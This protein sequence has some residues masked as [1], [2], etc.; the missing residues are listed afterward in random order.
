M[1]KI[2]FLISLFF[3]SSIGVS[4]DVHELNPKYQNGENIWGSA[5]CNGSLYLG[6]SPNGRIYRV[7]PP[8]VDTPMIKQIY[9]PD[10]KIEGPKFIHTLISSGNK[11]YGAVSNT[12]YLFSIN[13]INNTLQIVT[14]SNSALTSNG[15]TALFDAT[16]YKDSLQNKYIFF[17]SI[18]NDMLSF[19]KWKVSDNSD[20]IYV[21]KID[22][23]NPQ[24]QQMCQSYDIEIGKYAEF[25][26]E[27]KD[28]L[29]IGAYDDL[30]NYLV[31]WDIK[32]NRMIKSV[33]LPN[34]YII[35]NFKAD[36][37]RPNQIFV[38]NKKISRFD[39]TNPN[40]PPQTIIESIN[41]NGGS[42]NT[43]DDRFVYNYIDNDLYTNRGVLHTY[44]DP[45]KDYM[46]YYSDWKNLYS[47]NI[48]PVVD[49][50]GSKKI[51]G[52]DGGGLD[53]IFL[54]YVNQANHLYY[55][56][57]LHPLLTF[58]IGPITGLAA[59]NNIVYASQFCNR[60][61]MILKPEHNW[62]NSEIND[63][64]PNLNAVQSDK[65]VVW[66]SPSGHH[67]MI[68]G[69]YSGTGPFIKIKDINTGEK[70]G[71]TLS[72][73]IS[74]MQDRINEMTISQNNMLYM[75]TGT[76]NSTP[77]SPFILR[78]D[79]NAWEINK[80]IVGNTIPVCQMPSGRGMQFITSITC[81]SNGSND[82]IYSTIDH[83]SF[84]IIK[85]DSFG[86]CVDSSCY[87]SNS[88]KYFSSVLY[89]DSLNCIIVTECDRLY[90]IP[91]HLLQTASD[92][93]T[94]TATPYGPYWDFFHPESNDPTHHDFTVNLIKAGNGKFYCYNSPLT[95]SLFE[96]EITFNN[97]LP[98]PVH[99][100][101]IPVPDFIS[102]ISK[103]YAPALDSL[104]NVS[105]TANIYIGTCEGKIFIY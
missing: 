84:S 50:N 16:F 68:Y 100:H 13:S 5:Y 55:K 9:Q 105:S 90:I 8:D 76:S 99:T 22:L 33:H 64:I 10:Y 20:S 95:H 1:K 75:G 80:D 74:G 42:K 6:T 102:V 25:G 61:E 15:I 77:S 81:R 7:T 18:S 78:L 63:D 23:P 104:G 43:W 85:T 3:L 87:S 66:N 28:V 91:D 67:Y 62:I 94:Y 11:I 49:A 79:L 86:K 92:I 46:D 54:Y 101:R 58:P 34:G 39:V 103:D 21:Q 97:G 17:A 70:W 38:F 59:F 26:E 45:V 72:H 96:F 65:I 89:D 44:N 48:L 27:P 52:S 82:Y 71:D 19:I 41:W 12:P 88:G 83:K 40:Q 31:I 57:L 24:H 35:R 32:T 14:N 47:K 56:S 29:Y 60:T 73:K 36:K 53:S 69:L 51:F 30:N 37:D 93:E 2:Y 4:Q 98:K